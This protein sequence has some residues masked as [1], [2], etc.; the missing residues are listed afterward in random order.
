[1]AYVFVQHL[2]P[3]H[4]S[5]LVKILSKRAALSVEEA[6][7]GVKISPDRLYIITPNTTLTISNDVLHSRIRDPAEKPIVPLIFYSIRLLRRKGRMSLG[8]FS[9][10][11]GQTEQKDSSNQRGGRSHFRGGRKF[12]LLF[13]NAKQRNPNG[14]RGFCS[15][16]SLHERRS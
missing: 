4:G 2:N 11:A 13:W 16:P 7:D 6:R 9:L 5:D 14:L 3:R 1:M 8:L 15:N 10:E 12:C